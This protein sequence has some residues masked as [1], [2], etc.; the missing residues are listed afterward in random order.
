[1]TDTGLGTRLLAGGTTGALAVV[2]A[3]PTDVVK[4]RFQAQIQLPEDSSLKRYS[5]TTDAYR[6]I[7]KNEGVRGLWKGIFIWKVLKHVPKHLFLDIS[8][9][10]ISFNLYVHFNSVLNYLFSKGFRRTVCISR[11]GCQNRFSSFLLL[12]FCVLKLKLETS[13]STCF[14][15]HDVWVFKLL[16]VQSI[17]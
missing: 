9:A 2:F 14:V 10:N 6:I 13:K 11:G 15:F 17:T 7:A 4:V 16:V 3:Q 5:S 12:L 1:M 8:A